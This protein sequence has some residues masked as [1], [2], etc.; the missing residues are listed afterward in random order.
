MR[1]KLCLIALVFTAGCAKT[2]AGTAANDSS[3]DVAAPNI[4]V[5]TAPGV[6]FSYDYRFELPPKN[7]AAAQEAHQQACERLG[8]A[9]CRITGWH[10]RVV[11]ENDI[12]GSL[13]FLL[14]PRLARGFGKSAAAQV[15][16]AGGTL[17]E[18]EITGTDAGAQ[19]KAAQTQG[20][21]AG[22]EVGRIDRQLARADL[23][24]AERET[25]QS[26]RA[27]AAERART[28]GEQVAAGQASLAT[29]PMAFTYQSGAT[30][31]G[32]DQS[33]PFTSVIN[34]LVGS[35]ELTLAT[36]LTLLAVAG[37]PALVLLA[38]WWVVRVVRR[39]FGRRSAS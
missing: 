11:G 3:A 30:I 6:A 33:A 7:I 8:P 2:P 36:V 39:R 9:E 18:A 13:N 19:I 14:D 32:F 1:A 29:T 21:Q 10:Y 22:G 35:A 25:L 26:Q 15:T 16:G 28:A 34:L 31:H 27:D 38:G 23:P 4:D 12:E 37:P 24:R 20:Q 5:T 17:A